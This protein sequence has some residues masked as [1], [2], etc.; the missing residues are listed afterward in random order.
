MSPEVPHQE[1][2]EGNSC[3]LTTAGE[4]FMVQITS[5]LDDTISVTFPGRDYPVEGMGVTLDFHDDTGFN[6]YLTR[7]IEGP[8]ETRQGIILERPQGVNRNLHRD[9]FRVPTDLTVQVKDQ[10]HIRQ[11]D[12][13]LTNLSSGGAQILT[14][15]PFDFGTTV[16]LNLSLPEETI[17]SIMAQVVHMAEM[18]DPI[19]GDERIY[20]LQFVGLDPS[21]ARTISAYVWKRLKE[22]H[23]G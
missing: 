22:L 19:R 11:Y 7:V 17:H 8:N 20:G 21:A 12:A 3:L 16:E 1:L 9:S 6:R 18:S 15:A 5:V 10:V 13:A 4:H 2:V 14:S 23:R